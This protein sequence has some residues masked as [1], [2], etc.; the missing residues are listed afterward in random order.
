MKKHFVTAIAFLATTAAFAQ[1][2]DSVVTTSIVKK[3]VSAAPAKPVKKDWSKIDLTKRAN[4][5]FMFQL[6]YDNW[7]ARPDSIHISGFNRSANFYFM[8]DFPF[9]TDPRMSIGAGLGIGSSNIFFHQQEVMVAAQG[10]ATLA[11]PDEQNANHFKKYKL[12]TTYLE[13]PL[14][15]RYALDPENTN[16]S[17]KFAVGAKIGLML[18]AYTK[19]KTWQTS[20]GQTLGNF[21]E[22]ESSKQYFNTTKLAFTGRISKGVF[23]VFG[24]FQANSLIK[25]SA[26]PAVYPFSFGIV[27]SGL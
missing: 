4:D 23:G 19:G 2:K 11:F 6:G 10:N 12:V 16:K 7:A 22:K 17:W 25:T 27:L 26:G 1:N 15:L 24:S 5:H 3:P 18:N 21:T 8:F 14:E 13:V 9:K 20:S